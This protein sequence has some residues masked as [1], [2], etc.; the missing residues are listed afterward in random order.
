MNLGHLKKNH[1]AMI[2]LVG[3]IFLDLN[4]F[5]LI[6]PSLYSGL[7]ND[8]NRTGQVVMVFLVILTLGAT[9]RKKSFWTI[10]IGFFFVTIFLCGAFS[11]IEYN[12]SFYDIYVM[13]NFYLL[14]LLIPAL[15]GKIDSAKVLKMVMVMIAI[16]MMIDII[17][18][19]VYSVSGTIFVKNLDPESLQ[20]RNNILRHSNSGVYPSVFAL[21]ILGREKTLGQL[22]KLR[23]RVLFVVMA[24]IVIVFCAQTRST[25]FAFI[26]AAIVT[27]LLRRETLDAKC[28]TII[29]LVIFLG[30]ALQ[31]PQIQFMLETVIDTTSKEY[32]TI[33]VR[34][35]NIA[36]RMSFFNKNIFFGMGIIR[37]LGDLKA[38]ALGPKGLYFSSD[39][40]VFDTIAS[41]GVFGVILI[42]ALYFHWFSTIKKLI[43]GQL[44]SQYAWYIGI[45]VFFVISGVTIGYF[46]TTTIVCFSLTSYFQSELCEKGLHNDEI[47]GPYEL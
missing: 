41:F 28:I 2:L 26:A 5:G 30:I 47:I 3:I 35:E 44:A 14:I 36:Y 11:I 37:G 32:G 22:F 23:F 46:A 13:S 7:C 21:F 15:D 12:Q 33:T 42:L 8:L 29:V 31:N 27:L 34:N 10:Y 4:C 38:I 43:I 16:S 6:A 20:F 18:S 9:M 17:Q 19:V 1:I 25:L 40:G 45:V 24:V 39:V